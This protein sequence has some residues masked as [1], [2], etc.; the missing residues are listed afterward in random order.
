MSRVALAEIE[1]LTFYGDS[2]TKARRTSPIPQLKCVGETC[3]LYQ[4]EVVRCTNAGG[5]GTEI[6]W[7]VRKY[8]SYFHLILLVLVR[9]R[10]T[11]ISAIRTN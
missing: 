5:S 11:R 7:T 9:S 6:D 10:L 1:S 4:P 3:K 2:L 8:L